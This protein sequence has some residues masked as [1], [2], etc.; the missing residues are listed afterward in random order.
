MDVPKGVAC[1]CWHGREHRGLDVAADTRIQASH[2]ETS[3]HD[4]QERN[5][6]EIDMEDSVSVSQRSRVGGA[7]DRYEGGDDVVFWLSSYGCRGQAL[8][9]RVGG[10]VWTYFFVLH[11]SLQRQRTHSGKVSPMAILHVYDTSQAHWLYR[12]TL[13]HTEVW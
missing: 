1:M 6:R 4:A 12:V 5:L 11:F 3:E 9:V 10:T 2:G 8:I 13:E 7:Q